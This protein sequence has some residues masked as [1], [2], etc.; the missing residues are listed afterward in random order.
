M[1][2]FFDVKTEKFLNLDE[3][4]I[5]KNNKHSAIKIK[6]K[7][8]NIL[9]D[10]LEKIYYIFDVAKTIKDLNT[11]IDEE[12][13]YVIKIALNNAIWDDTYGVKNWKP[14]PEKVELN[15][16]DSCICGALQRCTVIGK[17]K[18][19]YYYIKYY[20]SP[21][22]V[23]KNPEIENNP[24][25]RPVHWSHVFPVVAEP[26]TIDF[27]ESDVNYSNTCISGLLMKY[28]KFGIDMNPEYQRGNVWTEEQQVK[29]IDS[30]YS[31]INIGSFVLVEKKWFEN[32]NVVSDMYEILDGKQRLTAIIDYVSSKFTYRG[33]YYHELS[34]YTRSKFE[35]QQILIGMMKLSKKDDSYNRKQVIK[36]F[37]RLNECGTS[38]EKSII[39]KA[40]EI[41][42]E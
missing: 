2:R 4:D 14:F 5:T 30:I 22:E 1:N 23:K 13:K 33:K 6:N 29:L 27:V 7:Y 25:Y 21:W 8:Y 39:D 19:G 38:M 17:D 42:N 26:M 36:Q 10:R 37:I 34:E 31:N 12:N 32:Y 3:K 9:F 16:G 18:R 11:E 20:P 24:H 40:K 41:V 35:N 15:I 28:F